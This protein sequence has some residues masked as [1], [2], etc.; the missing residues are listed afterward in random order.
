M[1]MEYSRIFNCS[2]TSFVTTI[3]SSPS[4][5]N[6]FLASILLENIIKKMKA[7]VPSN[8]LSNVIIS[9]VMIKSVILP[10]HTVDYRT[11]MQSK[12]CN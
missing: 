8:T 12:D 3:L 2:V 1:F 4:T 10:L 6:L 7:T 9:M 11:D 5:S